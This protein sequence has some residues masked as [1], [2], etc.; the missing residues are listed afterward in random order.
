TVMGQHLLSAMDLF[1]AVIRRPVFRPREIERL[2]AERLAEILQLRAE[3]RGLADEAFEAA[4][5]DSS[6]RYGTSLGGSEASVSAIGADD[7]RALY[8]ARYSPTSVTL[9][10]A[11][12][13]DM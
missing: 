5:Y 2:K 1:A 13:V 11:G 7:I 10:V 8:T 9:I 6:S 12:D 3:P 4:V